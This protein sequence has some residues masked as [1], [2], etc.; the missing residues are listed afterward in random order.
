MST[1]ANAAQEIIG[2][3]RPRSTPGFDMMDAENSP[4]EWRVVSHNFYV[5]VF[6]TWR[7]PVGLG[8]RTQYGAPGFVLCQ[9]PDELTIGRPEGGLPGSFKVLEFTPQ[10]LAEWLAEQ[11][12]TALRPEWSAA[13]QSLSPALSAKFGHFFEA[14]ALEASPLQLQSELLQ[15]SEVMVQGLIAGM[16]ERVARL[17]G[18]PIRGTARMREC[19]HEEGFDIDLETLASK[20]G[21]SRFQALRAFK[22]RYGLPPHAY[23]MAIRLGQARRMLSQGGAPVDVALH[24]GFVDQSHFNRHFKRA[25]GVTPLRYARGER[26]SSGVYLVSK[27]VASDPERV[28]SRSDR[29]RP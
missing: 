29:N 14:F 10:L 16:P 3:R 20:V 9:R 7:G 24:C 4:R 11:P 8:G 26:R 25:Y 1:V 5:V 23:Q 13:I 17:D 2:F 27:A 12:G 15:L 6:G 18:P 28:V 22:R 19:L 21:L